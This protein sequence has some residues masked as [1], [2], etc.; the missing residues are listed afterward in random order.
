MVKPL[1]RRTLLR[2]AGGIAIALP[3]LEAMETKAG[4]TKSNPPRFVTFFQPNGTVPGRWEPIGSET[5]FVLDSPSEPGRLLAPL[6]PVKNELVILDGVDMLSRFEGEQAPPH[7]M[8]MAHCLTATD[9]V[10]KNHTTGSNGQLLDGSA[11]GPSIDQVVADHIGTTTTF[12]SLQL[13][14]RATLDSARPLNC[15]MCYRG[16]YEPLAPENDPRSAFYTIF[17]NAGYTPEQL[18]RIRVRRH[19]ILDYVRSDFDTLNG[20]LG[21]NDRVKLESHLD[22]IR[23]LEMT[24]D[25]M[26]TTENCEV[27]S[28]PPVMA[29]LAGENFPEVGRLMMELLAM[30]LACDLT[31]V[32]SLQW[33][34][35]QSWTVL[36]WLGATQHHHD[37]SHQWPYSQG[38]LNEFENCYR[39]YSE[40]FL[41][42]VNLLANTIE[43]DGSRLLDSTVVLWV[44][45]QG[46]GA[47]HE[48]WSVPY[49]IAGNYQNRINSGRYLRYTSDTPHNNLFIAAAQA[50]G[51]NID[52]FG[53]P[54]FS[55]G[56]LPGALA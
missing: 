30:S 39:W 42:F 3:F 6:E 29:H 1:S 41:Y 20:K 47:V 23:E 38:V 44:N 22:A 18:E 33:H 9:I 21:S 16:P 40:Q 24:L 45:E 2:G 12:R 7:D 51:A 49:V 55:T 5:D 11:G 50:V 13:G 56:P 34:V 31:R 14:V 10:S 36:S 53:N 27:P 17:A 4:G 25:A 15:R 46:D 19:S 43:A 28:A 35:S 54:N 8:G 26:G 52:S 37:L 48:P 32:A